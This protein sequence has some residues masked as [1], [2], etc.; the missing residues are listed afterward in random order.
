[1]N[2]SCS[3]E[4]VKGKKRSIGSS[5]S[6]KA[7]WVGLDDTDRPAAQMKG[8]SDIL[9]SHVIMWHD[10]MLDLEGCTYLSSYS[11]IA[12]VLLGLCPN[13][14]SIPWEALSYEHFF[15]ILAYYI[16]HAMDVS[17]RVSGNIYNSC[18][19]A[20]I[21]TLMHSCYCLAPLKRMKSGSRS[22]FWTSDRNLIHYCTFL[23]IHSDALK[24]IPCNSSL[25]FT[26]LFI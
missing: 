5:H 1:M 17:D 23:Y 13:K 21:V 7:H 20:S 8:S 26:I 19:V 12:G 14:L 25:N 10:S 11:W 4:C 24:N 15:F 6:S 18:G 3:K 9:P 22:F 2:T 16:W